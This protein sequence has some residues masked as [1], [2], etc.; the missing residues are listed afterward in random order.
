MTKTVL[1]TVFSLLVAAGCQ[2]N[3]LPLRSQVKLEDL[4]ERA[5]QQGLSGSVLLME[6]D[7]LLYYRGLGFADL[8]AQIPSQASTV[9]PFGS[10]VKDYTR[11][12]VFQEVVKGNLQMDQ[13]LSYFFEG[14][15]SD[16]KDITLAQLIRH[17]AGLV[18]YHD[19]GT[20]ERWPDIPADLRPMTREETLRIILSTPLKFD[21][22]VDYSYSNSGYTLLALILEKVTKKAFEELCQER[23]FYPAEMS[24]TDFYNSPLWKA[25][26]TAVGYGRVQYG[27]KNSPYY[28]PRNPMPIF[29][30]GGIAGPLHDLYQST[31][32]LQK[33]KTDDPMLRELYQQYKEEQEPESSNLIGSAGGNDLGYVAVTFGRIKEDQYLLFAS[34]N[35]QDG[36]EDMDLLRRILIHGFGFDLAKAIP[37]AFAEEDT[38]D[39]YE[40]IAAGDSKWGLPGGKRWLSVEAFLTTIQEWEAE[41]ATAFIH[42]HL[43]KEY[44][45][46]APMAAHLKLLQSWHQGAPFELDNILVED[47]EVTIGLVQPDGKHK[48]FILSLSQASKPKITDI[49]Y[50]P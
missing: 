49:K 38:N 29:G 12:L 18:A 25:E 33:L 24:Q 43:G 17:R 44:R 42:E 47:E 36:I 2:R 46:S 11:L 16:K 37:G 26:D 3:S 10:I 34:N 15:P 4:L 30:N 32:Y 28:W 20:H 19:A 39:D 45:E 50:K 6:K 23:I 5:E 9:Y 13:T 22:G 21:P 41:L 40:F 1:L 8:E 31:K 35:N 7:S 48:T 27:E 14:T